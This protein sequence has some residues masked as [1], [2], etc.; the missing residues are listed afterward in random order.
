MSASFGKSCTVCVA[1]LLPLAEKGSSGVTLGSEKSG[2]KW[3]Y[4]EELCGKPAA[5]A[6]VRTMT[7]ADIGV[8]YQPIVELSTGRIFAHEALVRCRVP[9]LESPPALFARAELER[10]CG[11]LGRL[12]RD[13]TFREATSLPLFVNIHPNELSERWL[14]RPDDPIGFHES[15]VYLEITESAALSHPDLAMNVLKDVCSR[16]EARLVVDDLGAGHADIFRVLDLEPAVVKLD[17]A[18]VSGLDK[19]RDQHRRVSYFVDL[20]TELGSLVVAEG[21]ETADELRALQDTGAPFGQGYLLAHPAYPTPPINWSL[22]WGSVDS[23]TGKSL[24]PFR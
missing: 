19:N 18:L 14:V 2:L 13:V 11:R 4:S 10:C 8:V 21:V 12:I 9:G 22:E 3:S 5:D 7:H 16:V 6:I 23:P 24:R 20:C 17:R 15:D 1:C